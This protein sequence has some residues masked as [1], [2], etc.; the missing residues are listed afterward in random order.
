MC[1][2]QPT[3]AALNTDAR[4]QLMEPFADGEEREEGVSLLDEAHELRPPADRVPVVAHFALDLVR[5]HLTSEDNSQN[6]LTV[7]SNGNC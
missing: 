7:F 5:P 3:S 6:S 4:Y 1:R 2:G